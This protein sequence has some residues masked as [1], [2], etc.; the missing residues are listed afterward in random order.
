MVGVAQSRG[1]NASQGRGFFQVAQALGVEFPG[2][3]LLPDRGQQMRRRDFLRIERVQA[4]HTDRQPYHRTQQNQ[5]HDPAAGDYQFQHE[6]VPL[7]F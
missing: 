3:E 1:Q 5:H 2:L 7:F 4:F 6:Y